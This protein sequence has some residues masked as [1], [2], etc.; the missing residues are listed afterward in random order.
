MHAVITDS[1]ITY[2]L[3]KILQI[4]THKTNKSDSSF[5]PKQRDKTRVPLVY[6]NNIHNSVNMYWYQ[7][8]LLGGATGA[9]VCDNQTTA[10]QYEM[11]FFGL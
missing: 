11:L 9:S 1:F 2:F 7:F 8:N 10:P 6:F 4:Q 3:I 5:R